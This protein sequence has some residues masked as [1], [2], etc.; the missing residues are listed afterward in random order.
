M[1]CTGSLWSL[2]FA[3]ACLFLFTAV[4][5]SVQYVRLITAGKTLQPWN[6]QKGM[7]L[8]IGLGCCARGV[9]LLL[10]L[11]LWDE[12]TGALDV[13]DTTGMR[14]AFYLM[15]QLAYYAAFSAY[16]LLALF[17]AKLY[18]LSTSCSPI[19]INIVQPV[20]AFANL[21]VYVVAIVFWILYGTAWSGFDLYM[22]WPFS[23]YICALYL[24]ATMLIV[25]FGR[26]SAQELRMVPVEVS[27]RQIKLRQVTVIT[28]LCGSAMFAKA[29][30]I[31]VISNRHLDLTSVTSQIK[32]FAYFFLLEWLPYAAL[33]YFNRR[34]PMPRDSSYAQ[35]TRRLLHTGKT[36]D[37][38][39]SI[40]YLS[41]RR[42]APAVH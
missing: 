11:L 41:T 22:N 35:E 7:H 25:T 5:S 39:A 27:L 30:I 31:L 8:V 37:V 19:F 23:A 24:A 13:R 36:P 17:S 26:L 34:R 3:L 4:L 16:I 20:S 40:R 2:A 1:A 9:L 12:E 33:L 10:A 42:E 28:M 14:V 29:A 38:E 21:V 15:D 32:F 6:L 18:F